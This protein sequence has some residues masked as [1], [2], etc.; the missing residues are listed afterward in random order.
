MGCFPSLLC[1]RFP[2]QSIVTKGE[3]PPISKPFDSNS[4]SCKSPSSLST[5]L[6]LK[7]PKLSVDPPTPALPP[8]PIKAYKEP[9]DLPTDELNYNIASLTT[10][11]RDYSSLT[12]EAKTNTISDLNSILDTISENSL[13]Y[14]KLEILRSH[15]AS[16]YLMK[17]DISIHYFSPAIESFPVLWKEFLDLDEETQQAEARRQSPA[18]GIMRMFTILA[19]L[20]GACNV[21]QDLDGGVE[22]KV[23]SQFEDILGDLKDLGAQEAAMKWRV[24]GMVVGKR[25]QEGERGLEEILRV[26]MRVSGLLME[27]V[28]GLGEVDE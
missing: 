4:Q 19:S 10:A 9:F 6:E 13:V 12:A 23:G 17:D 24:L 14:T 21:Q 27:A 2:G 18:S 22:K 26:R 28:E 15:I 20:R 1:W 16:L 11:I 25:R 5:S 8:E 3:H 7:S